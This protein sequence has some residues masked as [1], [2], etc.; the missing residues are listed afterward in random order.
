MQPIRAFAAGVV[1]ALWL[2]ASSHC[3]LEG[4]SAFSFLSCAAAGAS[5]SSPASHCDDAACQVVESGQYVSSVQ[6]KA[7]AAALGI[8]VLDLTMS[9][10]TPQ[11]PELSG[12]VLTGAP[13]DLPKTWQF[14]LRA[15]LAPRAPSLIV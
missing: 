9:A 6:A 8:V 11:V 12:G 7:P 2:V 1:A 15:A 5:E 14:R 4:V 13:P 3:L 10:E